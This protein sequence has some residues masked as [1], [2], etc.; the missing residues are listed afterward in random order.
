ML[1][2]FCMANAVLVNRATPHTEAGPLFDSAEVA[3]SGAGDR[4][5]MDN[6]AGQEGE[7]T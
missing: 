4:A 5:A 6:K 1:A 2:P 3:R 7:W